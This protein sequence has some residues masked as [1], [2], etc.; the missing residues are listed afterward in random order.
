MAVFTPVSQVEA[1]D[2]LGSYDLGRLQALTP[3]IEGVENTNYRLETTAGRFVLTLFEHR[4]RADALPFCLGL[5]EHLADRGYPAPRPMADRAGHWISRLNGRPAS[6][7]EWREGD[8][9]RT[10]DL[11]DQRTAGRTLA[12][13]HLAAL[14]FDGQRTN[15]VGP[16]AWRELADRCATVADGEDRRMLQRLEQELA[17]MVKRS[18]KTLPQGPVHMDYFPDNVLFLNG[19]I[20]GVID[21][22]FACVDTLAYDLAIALNAWGFDATG[23]ANPPAIAAFL[24]GYESVRPLNPSERAALPDLGAQAVVRFTLTRLHDRL[25]A[26]PDAL[27]TAKDPAPFLRRLDYW[28]AAAA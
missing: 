12:Q 7:I 3:I 18:L 16:A 23:G 28:R 26:A 4:T 15:P 2:F 13:L 20:S 10:P 1:G 25:M 22:Y 9:L 14:D 21:F 6:I 27:V 24:A 8:W 5:T 19:A 11:D 17:D